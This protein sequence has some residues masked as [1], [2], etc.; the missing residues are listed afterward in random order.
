MDEGV[1][2]ERLHH[3][4]KR[5]ARHCQWLHASDAD[6]FELTIDLGD[7][8]GYMLVGRHAHHTW[9]QLERHSGAMLSMPAQ[10]IAHAGDALKYLRTGQ[11]VG[12]CG[13]SRH[14][15]HHDP[16]VLRQESV[17]A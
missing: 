12:P 11:N 4:H 14:T 15:E 8:T 7:R 1:L 3:C 17:A 6:A 2:Y 16:I 9:F 5:H 10:A 13:T